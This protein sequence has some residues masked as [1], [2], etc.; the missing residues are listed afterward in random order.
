VL[1]N[2]EK[3]ALRRNRLVLLSLIRAALLRVA[4]FGK[5]EG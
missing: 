4:D 1:V 5:I 2:A 3:P